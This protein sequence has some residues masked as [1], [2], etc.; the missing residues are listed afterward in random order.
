MTEAQFV[1]AEMLFIV[2]GILYAVLF[3]ARWR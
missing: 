1:T 2:S 3:Y